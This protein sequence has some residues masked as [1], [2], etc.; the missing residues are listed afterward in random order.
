MVDAARLPSWAPVADPALLDALARAAWAFGRLDQALAGHSLG[1]AFLYRARLESVRLQAAVDGAAIDPWH[2]AAVLEG[3]R[4]RM[5]GALRIIDRGQIFAAARHALTLHQWLTE[6]DFDLEGEV[7]QAEAGLAAYAG[8]STPLLAGTQAFHAWIEGGGAR[9]PMRAALVRHWVQHRLLR[10]PVPLTGAAALRADAPW[11]PE[12][13]IPA[14]LHAVAEEADDALQLLC[15]LERGWRAVRAAV[16]GRRRQSRA[17]AAI[18]LLAAAPLLSASSLARAL[19]MAV[20]NAAALLDAFEAAG[21]A[22]EVSRRSKRRLYGLAGLAPL[23]DE[24]APPRRPEPGRGRGRPPVAPA[25]HASQTPPLPA[26]ALTP[27]LHRD[28]DTSDL[29]AAMAFADE[30]IRR[31]RRNLANLRPGRSAR[32]EAPAPDGQEFAPAGNDDPP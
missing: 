3:L 22:V 14:F 18:D 2:L 29:E 4:L 21:I 17:P 15:D 8:R 11:R 6:P 19:G 31:V 13:W 26:P 9:A 24:V 16:A 1:R 23:R 12:E 32:Q 27:I 30:T 20:K 5:D 10:L 28:F 25:E 7:K